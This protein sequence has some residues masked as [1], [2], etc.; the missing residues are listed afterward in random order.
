M[1]KYCNDDNTKDILKSDIDE[2]DDIF[3]SFAKDTDEFKAS[4]I[5]TF[6]EAEKLGVFYDRG[7]LRLTRGDDI[8][9]LDH[10]E[11]RVKMNYCPMC[12]RKINEE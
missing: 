6:Y 10:S 5:R 3:L 4:Y 8:G 1:C 9:C 11:D 7:Y 2:L 12:G